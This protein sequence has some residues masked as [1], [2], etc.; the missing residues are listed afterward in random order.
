MV[1]PSQLLELLISPLTTDYLHFTI[2]RI[3]AVMAYHR[4]R[5]GW[6]QDKKNYII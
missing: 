4:Y 6:V 3:Q 5:S 1:R 2:G